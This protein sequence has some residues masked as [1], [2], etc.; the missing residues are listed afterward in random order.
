MSEGLYTLCDV[1]SKGASSLVTSADQWNFWYLFDSS[2]YR[3][4]RNCEEL[5]I[6]L[7]DMERDENEKGASFKEQ[8]GTKHKNKQVNH[9]RWASLFMSAK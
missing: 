6:T 4:E 1:T 9:S 8:R 5:F 2:I 7:Y 3:F